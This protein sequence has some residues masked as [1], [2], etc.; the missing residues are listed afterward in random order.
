MLSMN[1]LLL[2][3]RVITGALGGLFIFF[4]GIGLLMNGS[5]DEP[6]FSSSDAALGVGLLLLGSLYLMPVIPGLRPNWAVGYA[7]A[8]IAVVL[9]IASIGFVFHSTN[10][11][12]VRNGLIPAV[13]LLTLPISIALLTLRFTKIDSSLWKDSSAHETRG[14]SPRVPCVRR[15]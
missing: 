3:V 14:P 1:T 13:V 8:N 4:G 10:Y 9:G 12:L 5:V 11:S 2:V 15:G 7:V 6:W